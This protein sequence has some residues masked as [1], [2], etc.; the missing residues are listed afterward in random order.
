MQQITVHINEAARFAAELLRAGVM[1]EAHQ[2][3][4]FDI[5]FKLTGF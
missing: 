5:L 3:N 2:V 4:A 1:F